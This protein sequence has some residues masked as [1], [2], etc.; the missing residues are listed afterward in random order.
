MEVQYLILAHLMA[1]HLLRERTQV[2]G[3]SELAL[4]AA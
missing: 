1:V 2:R 3:L 4:A